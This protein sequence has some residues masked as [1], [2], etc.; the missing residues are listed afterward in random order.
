MLTRLILQ[1]HSQKLILCYVTLLALH[2][3]SLYTVLC[4]YV[5]MGRL[6]D[7]YFNIVIIFI[8]KQYNLV[9]S[10]TIIDI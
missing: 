10:M 9:V 5:T 6:Q 8:Y 4:L 7:F 2:K 1:V 3:I